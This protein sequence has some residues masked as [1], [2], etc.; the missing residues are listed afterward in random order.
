[1]PIISIAGQKGGSPRIAGTQIWGRTVETDRR[2]FRRLFMPC[3]EAISGPTKAI[4][5]R[6]MKPGT[7]GKFRVCDDTQTQ[8]LDREDLGR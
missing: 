8:L 4:E 6:I 7:C 1:M 5:D 3:S 2:R